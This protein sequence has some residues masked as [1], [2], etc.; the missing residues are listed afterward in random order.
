MSSKTLT[1]LT[2]CLH[3]ETDKAVLVSETGDPKK[4]VWIPKSQCEVS[5]TEKVARV[6]GGKSYP[7]VEVT[8]PEWLAINKDLA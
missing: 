6:E 1:D 3:H 5:K 8:M 4:S 7:V 2:L